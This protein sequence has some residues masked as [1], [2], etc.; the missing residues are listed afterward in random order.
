M[1]AVKSPLFKLGEIVATPGAVQCLANAQTPAWELLAR[2]VSGD[3]G[4]VDEEDR[5][6]NE[7]AIK[8]NSRVLSAYTLRTG[9]RL[10]VITE[11]DRSSTCL[12]RPEDY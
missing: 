1:I 11:A 4:D 10:W 12:L 8:D 2:H 6:A 7:E 9:E 5:R 3:F